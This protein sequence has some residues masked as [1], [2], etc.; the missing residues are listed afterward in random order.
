MIKTIRHFG[1]EYGGWWIAPDLLPANGVVID[2]GVGTD[3]SFCEKVRDEFPGLRFIGVDHTDEAEEYANRRGCYERFIKAAVVGD[4]R[5][6]VEMFRNAKGGS[7]S[8]LADHNFVGANSYSVPAV[9]LAQLVSFHKP[10][11][12]KMDI[13][14]AEYSC[15]RDAFGAKQVLLEAHHR[16]LHS[17]TEQDTDKMIADFTAHGYEVVHRT[18]RDEFLLVMR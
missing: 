15:Y 11:L 7:E 1:T 12:V 16:M 13:E 17:H 3:T 18:E 14:G 6:Y 8:I 10:C 2:A 5:L 4:E 9:R